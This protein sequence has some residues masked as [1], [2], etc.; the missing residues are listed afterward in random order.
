MTHNEIMEGIDSLLTLT[1]DT[2]E[3]IEIS[4]FI[5]A[6]TSLASEY[7]RELKENYPYIKNDSKIYVKEI[8]QGSVVADLVPMFVSV[9]PVVQSMDTALILDQFV[10]RYAR[11]ISNMISGRRDQGYSKSEL[12]TFT[13]TIQAVANDPNATQKLESAKFRDGKREITA[14]FQFTTS[15]AKE[16]QKTI[17]A[18]YTEID[19]KENS[20]HVRV[21]MVFTRSDIKDA[22]IGKH[23]GELVTIEEISEKSLAL[24]YA[25]ETAEQRIKHEIREA[26]D[27]VFKKGFVVDVNVQHIR[28]KPKVYAITNFH[29]IIDLPDD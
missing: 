26:D 9:M 5:G 27:N 14:S 7:D 11:G 12:K 2:S 18:Y 15:E 3:P 10:N 17:E 25:S 22:G 29:S 20:D 16:A 6:F 21:L 8:R 23:S 28:G 1:L 19:Q 4:H 13:D 24:M